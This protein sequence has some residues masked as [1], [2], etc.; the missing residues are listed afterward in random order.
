[1][2]ETELRLIDVAQ[3]RSQL[4]KALSDLLIECFRP[5]FRQT[6]NAE[7]RAGQADELLTFCPANFIGGF[8]Q[9]RADG[10]GIEPD[11]PKINGALAEWDIGDG[12]CRRIIVCALA[13][14][15]EVNHQLIELATG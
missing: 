3:A 11:D 2:L 7:F 9:T 4:G 1:M 6:G 8:F 10:A 5:D 15:G 14:F 12:A 13:R